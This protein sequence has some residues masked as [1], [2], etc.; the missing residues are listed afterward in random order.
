MQGATA[1]A[2]VQQ[3]LGWRSDRATEILN[4]LQYA[5]NQRQARIDHASISS[6]QTGNAGS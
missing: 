1:V 6:T 2:E 3:I 5:Q 4:A